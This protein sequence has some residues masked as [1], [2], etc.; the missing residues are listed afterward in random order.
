ME[1]CSPLLLL[2]L[3]EKFTFPKIF[4]CGEEQQKVDAKILLIIINRSSFAFDEFN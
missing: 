1:M 4:R 3:G 2:L